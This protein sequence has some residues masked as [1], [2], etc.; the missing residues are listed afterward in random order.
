MTSHCLLVK[1][2]SKKFAGLQA[3]RDLTLRVEAGER[4]AVIGPNGAGK[5]TL[6][7]L[8]S[9]SLLPSSGEIH[10]FGRDV[11]RLPPHRRV[12][13]GLARTFQITNLFPSLSL[14]ENVLLAVQAIEG[15]NFSALYGGF[16]RKRLETRSYE[17]LEEWG[18][19]AKAAELVR[20]LSHGDQ[21]QVDLILALAG[22]PKLLLLD[23]PTAGL[24]P[25]ETTVVAEA[26]RSLDRR[27][28]I[29]L[30]EH[31]MDVAFSLADRVSVLHLG[32]LL[33]EGSVE[34]IKNDPKVQEIYLGE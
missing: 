22:K 24:S 9:G 4:R 7:N 30:V 34:E 8:V 31:D 29:L 20:N 27:I 32:S 19:R 5:T 12:V 28:T 18:M 25:A 11:T 15:V 16:A 26:I 14:L 13:L 1:G 21:R 6:F 3:I 23:E 2:L 17:L 10:I 33:A